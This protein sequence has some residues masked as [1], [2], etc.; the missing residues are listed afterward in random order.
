M[1]RKDDFF[2]HFISISVATVLK[3]YGYRKNGL[4]W[5]RR[6]DQIIYV[7]NIQKSRFSDKGT[8]KF[9]LNL[10]VAA[11]DIW[12]AYWGMELPKVIKEESCFPGFRVGDVLNGFSGKAKDLWW[13]LDA[14]KAMDPL[15]EEVT[16]CLRNR[17]LPVLQ[18]LDSLYAV[19]DFVR[20]SN[21]LMMPRD[22]ICWGILCHQLGDFDGAERAFS[23]FE[24]GKSKAW[25]SK[26]SEIRSRL[27]ME[28]PYEGG[29][30]SDS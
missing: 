10:G 16:S 7:V 3:E 4:T 17:C 28:K 18:Q 11:E 5:N 6:M 15:A 14:S 9:T 27:G 13:F 22:R 2:S 8:V 24:S 26:V 25:Q 21:P 23:K 20:R 29:P 19:A 30:L 1:T 12:L